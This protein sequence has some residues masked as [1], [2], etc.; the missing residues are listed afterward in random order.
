MRTF[1]ATS[2]AFARAAGRRQGLHV[3]DGR[4]KHPG[5]I[6]R[7]TAAD[8]AAPRSRDFRSCGAAPG[9]RG[10][11]HVRELDPLSGC[12]PLQYSP[13]GATRLIRLVSNLV[14]ILLS[15][16]DGYRAEGLEAL[17]RAI[18][19]LG[20]V[21]VVAPD[22]NRSGASNSLT[23]DVP[24]RAARYDTDCYYVNGT[25]TDCVHLAISGLFD[26][27]HDIVVSGVND[28]ANLGDDT[29]YSGTVAAAVEGRFLGLPAIAVSL[30]R[31][32]RQ[33]AQFRERRSSRREPG[34]AIGG[35]TAQGA[36]DAQRQRAGF[37]RGTAAGT[38]G[39]AARQSAPQRA[40]GARQ[41]SARPQRLLGRAPRAPVRMPGRARI[42]MRL[43]TASPR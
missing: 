6:G 43:R 21:T 32:A 35:R 13:Q 26:F 17:R 22:R 20:S 29:L 25:P 28:G 16:D 34:R 41:G 37:A 27:E 2:R 36:R 7:P 31:R 33:P 4:P 14:K 1:G 30:V 23:L 24:V 11:D 9:G 39:D 10:F 8:A 15:N 40:G 19:P 12:R 3:P 18:S 38:Q 5:I 42:F